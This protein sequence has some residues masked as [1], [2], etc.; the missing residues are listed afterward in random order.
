M[1]KPLPAAKASP[2]IFRRILLYMSEVSIAWLLNEPDVLAR[3]GGGCTL[4]PLKARKVFEKIGLGSDF[5]ERAVDVP[6]TWL[7]LAQ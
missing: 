1:P 3:D 7:T 4:P 2:E 6:W 5:G